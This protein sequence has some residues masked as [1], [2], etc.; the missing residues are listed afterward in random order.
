M[1]D[2]YKPLYKQAAAMQ[3]KFHDYTYHNA[4][5]PTS[6]VLRQQIHN[7]TTDLATNK[8]PRTIENRLRTIQTQLRQAQR[9]GTQMGSITGQP[10][11]LNYRQNSFLKNNF[12]HM[13]TDVRQHPHF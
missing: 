11:A 9:Q 8:N 6:M 1:D 5:D 4:A 7:L 13:R 12:E 2:Y 10:Q 3:H